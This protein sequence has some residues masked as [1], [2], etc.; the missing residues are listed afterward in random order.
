MSNTT[1]E[2]WLDLLAAP[3]T[4]RQVLKAALAGTALTLPFA[5]TGASLGADDPHA[6]QKGC[7]YTSHKQYG[8][9]VNACSRDAGLSYMTI[10]LTLPFALAI[11]APTFMMASA[12]F[13]ACLD[14]AL[15]K[16]KAMQRDCLS[17]NC[18]GF[19]PKGP[20]GP[21]EGLPPNVFCCPTQSTFHGYSPCVQC[22]SKTGSGC[23]SG[24]TECGSDPHP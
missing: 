12:K 11:G 23:G 13:N 9:G 4:R 7:F 14:L 22:C 3:R 8:S 1:R 17:P 16:E 21:C 20:D 24:V 10:G 19:D 15:L 2:H 18:P 6:C 5:R